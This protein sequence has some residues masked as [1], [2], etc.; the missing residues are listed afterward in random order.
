MKLH[1]TYNDSSEYWTKG[2]INKKIKTITLTTKQKSLIKSK[3][4]YDFEERLLIFCILNCNCVTTL[5]CY[6]ADDQNQCSHNERFLTL[7]LNMKQRRK[8]KREYCEYDSNKKVYID[9]VVIEK[10]EED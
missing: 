4:W 7:K 5:Y 9:K 6:Y 10:E 1:V 3:P 2:I 8:L